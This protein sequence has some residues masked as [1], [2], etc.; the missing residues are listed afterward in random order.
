MSR[1]GQIGLSVAILAIGAFV[2]LALAPLLAAASNSDGVALASP[3]VLR[4]LRFTLLQA[5]LSTILSVGLAVPVALALARRP[6]FRG[7]SLILALLALPVGLPPL[8]AV[9]G[10]VTIFGGAGILTAALGTVGMPPLPPLYGLAGILIAHVFFNMPLAA[11]LLLVAIEAVPSETWRLADELDLGPW[12][13]FRIIDWPAMRAVLPDIA[14]LVFMLCAASFT[15]VLTLGGGPGATTLEVAIYQALRFDFDPAL[16]GRLALAQAALC[17][18]TMLAAAPY[19]RPLAVAP[20]LRGRTGRSVPSGRLTRAADAAMIG[21]ATLFVGLPIAAVIGAGLCVM[22]KA[23]F[24]TDAIAPLLADPAI[25]SALVTS[26]AIAGAAALAAL[27][28]AWPI[29]SAIAA[30]S[31]RAGHGRRLIGGALEIVASTGLVLPPV[32]LGAGLLLLASATGD[33]ARLA[34][35]IVVAINALAALPFV[36]RTLLPAISA[37]A[38]RHDRL[39]AG[40]GIEGFARLRLVDLPVMRRPLALAG[41]L[42]LL[43]GLGDLGAIALFGASGIETLPLLLFRRMGSYRL[44]QAA[45]VALVLLVL[46]LGLAVIAERLRREARP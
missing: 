17:A 12:P 27:V 13:A 15:V 19:G 22:P 21:A 1:R 31:A 39:C 20:T 7:R 32:V 42:A 34:G 35:A 2:A 46:T 16:A 3:Y 25:W 30:L 23:C 5:V 28:L 18:V 10:I 26:L 4:A 11:R 37:G 45:G 44:D 29:A 14:T 36:T 33:P 9:L 41:L 38:G 43:V 6:E 40:L 8:V 24:Q